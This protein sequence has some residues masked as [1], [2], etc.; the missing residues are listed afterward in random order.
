MTRKII[1]MLLTF[2]LILSNLCVVF[3]SENSPFFVDGDNDEPSKNVVDLSNYRNNN[4]LQSYNSNL[5]TLSEKDLQI[6]APLSNK[7]LPKRAGRINLTLF[8]QETNY[9]CGP[10]TVKQTIHFINGSSENQSTIASDIGTTSDGSA[11]EPMVN[12][13][14]DRKSYGL[15]YTIYQN[16][17]MEQIQNIVNYC[18]EKNLPAICRLRFEKGGNWAY[19]TNGHY[20][21]ANGYIEY[22]EEIL[23]T[24]PNIKRVNSSSTGS[25]YVTINELYKATQNHP[26]KQMAV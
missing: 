22:G 24:D 21:N 25:Y 7:T 2:T 15:D 3:A 6:I 9:Y 14:N 11:L 23:L 20:L 13:I 26:Q 18:V 4:R 10:A 16:P 8:T 17:S 12:Y 5:K 19:R 1:I